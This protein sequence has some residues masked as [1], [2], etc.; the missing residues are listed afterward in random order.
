MY[1][2]VAPLSAEACPRNVIS[3]HLIGILSAVIA[4]FVFGLLGTG[5]DLP[6]LTLRRVFA[7]TLSLA[8]TFAVMTWLHVPHAPAGATTLIV[9][10]GLLHT[11]LDL[12]IM[13]LAVVMLVVIAAVINRI[14]GTRVPLWGP[15]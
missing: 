3:G 12:V 13:M 5:P 1:A 7:V 6:D 9:A 11:P 10:L 2:F 15:K 8:L 14:H 4:L